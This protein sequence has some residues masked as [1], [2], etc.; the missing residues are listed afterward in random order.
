MLTQI[1]PLFIPNSRNNRSVI[2]LMIVL[3]V[4]VFLVIWFVSQSTIFPTPVEII[5]ALGRLFEEQNLAYELWTSTWLCIKAMGIAIIISLLIAYATV[6]PFFKPIGFLISK[7]RFLTLVGL[8]FVFT[9]M[10]SGSSSLKTS[11]MVFGITVFFVTAM[12]S[13]IQSVPKYEFY[14]ARTLRMNEWQVVWEIIVL[15]RLDQV[16]EVIRQ[17]FAISWTMLTLVEG[18][19]RSEGG[20]GPLL[21]NQQKY[22]H[23]DAVFAIQFVILLIGILLDWGIGQMKDFFL[24]YSSLTVEK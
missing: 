9:Q 19:S 8:S 1:K 2:T 22:L 17:T 13:I 15:G 16:F 12:V 10:T 14:H 5:K 7:G 4:V 21:L 3:Q 20:I 11:L 23:L 24:P 18:I 6:I